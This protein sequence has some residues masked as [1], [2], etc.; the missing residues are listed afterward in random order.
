MPRGD[1]TGP[2]GLGPMTG[3]G[4]GDCAGYSIPGY[5][6]RLFGR[7][8]YLFRPTYR[9]MGYGMRPRWG[10]RGFFGRG[11]GRGARGGRW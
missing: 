11:R 7:A 10:L 9:P 2:S 5:A 1:R 8:T 6:N 4:A 3:R